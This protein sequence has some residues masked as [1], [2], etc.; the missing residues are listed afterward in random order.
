MKVKLEKIFFIITII[1]ISLVMVY[2]IN[3]K[4]GFHEDEIFSYGSSN[5]NLDNVDTA[6]FLTSSLLIASCYAFKDKIKE[7]SEKAH[8]D[9]DFQIS[10][11]ETEPIMTMEN[12]VIPDD[13]EG[14]IYVFSYNNFFKNDPKDSLQYKSY[15]NLQPIDVVSVHYSDFKEHYLL[16]KSKTIL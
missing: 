15:Q 3:Q 2:W 16:K 11:T 5:Y 6:V 7:E 8:L 12:V 13:L 10:S 1:I 4:E 9:W 14:Y